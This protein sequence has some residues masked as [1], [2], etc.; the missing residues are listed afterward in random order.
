MV[1]GITLAI[2]LVSGGDYFAGHHSATNSSGKSQLSA[3]SYRPTSVTVVTTQDL[4]YVD[5]EVVRPGVYL[6]TGSITVSNAIEVAGGRTQFAEDEMMELRRV[7]GQTNILDA[8]AASTFT[9]RRNDAIR[10]PQRQ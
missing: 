5:G 1:A 4:F 9:F 3:P 10:V 8:K 2:L 6:L 7:G